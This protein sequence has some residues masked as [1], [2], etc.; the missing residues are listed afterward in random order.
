MF[1]E[2]EKIGSCIPYADFVRSHLPPLKKKQQKPLFGGYE[3]ST[4]EVNIGGMWVQLGVSL[5]GQ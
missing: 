1:G 5:F 4:V 3:K 2:G